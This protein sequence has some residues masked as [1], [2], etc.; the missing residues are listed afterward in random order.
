MD[1][2]NLDYIQK[3]S[4]DDKEFE[5]QFIDIL[6]AEFPEEALTY[7][8]AI[9][10]VNYYDA[11]QIVHKLKH[12][13][14]ILSMTN[15]YALAVVFEEELNAENMGRDSEFLEALKIVDVY[16]KSI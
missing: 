8:K 6:K 7:E 10:E 12:K 9:S 11:A 14:N 15:A 1:K 3:L 16:L 13:F 2:P 5:K 4:G